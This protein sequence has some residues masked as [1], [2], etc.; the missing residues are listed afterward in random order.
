MMRLDP[1]QSL[2]CPDRLLGEMPGNRDL[3]EIAR[4]IMKCYGDAAAEEAEQRAQHNRE[5][6]DQEA[7]ELW[8]QVARAVRRMQGKT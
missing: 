2:G 1:H 4:Q 5:D 7:A 8:T 3:I 6:G